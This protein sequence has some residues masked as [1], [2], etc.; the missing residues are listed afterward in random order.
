M[1][2]AALAREKTP[3]N[4]QPQPSWGGGACAAPPRP[5]RRPPC[6]RRGHPVRRRATRRSTVEGEKA[7][8]ALASR[9][10]RGT[11]GVEG[12]AKA[13]DMNCGKGLDYGAVSF[14]LRNSTRW[15]RK[16]L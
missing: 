2:N 16:T 14:R 11:F 13:T 6:T 4:E 8:H 9:T 15:S 1:G 7:Q 12:K 3:T 5:K 10:M